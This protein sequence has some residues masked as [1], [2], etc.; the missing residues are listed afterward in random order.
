M[1]KS[2][3]APLP[4]EHANRALQG[5]GTSI[6][7]E[8]TQLAHSCNA[9][10]LGQ[11]FPNFDGPDAI[12]AR[13]AAAISGTIDNQYCRPH[14]L[15]EL[16]RAISRHQQRFW[17]L[18]YDPDREI[19]VT[20]GA[21]EAICSSLLG[22]CN[23]G[24]KVLVFAPFYDAYPACIAMAGAEMVVAKLEGPEFR[25]TPEILEAHAHPDLTTL[26]L[27]Q[28]HN[29]SGRVF[30]ADELTAIAEFCQKH[31]I[32]ALSD[33]VYEHIVF[34]GEH[35]PLAAVGDMHKRCLTI[36]SAG[37]TF[38]LTGWK[39]GHACGPSQLTQAL[40]S[41]HQYVTF[42]TPPALQRAVAAAYELGDDY[43]AELRDDYRQRRDL[44]ITGLRGAGLQAIVPAGSYFALTDIRALGWTD[45][46]SFAIELTRQRKVATIPCSPFYHAG[47]PD[48]QL[49]RWA[50]CKTR[51]QLEQGL[52]QLGDLRVWSAKQRS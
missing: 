44:L 4:R 5:F 9:V 2:A 46:R 45:D 26:I 51:D 3:P 15:P 11:G 43:Y 20:S 17:Q 33:E 16:N 39:V 38:S 24:D 47:D 22:L 42:C 30:D 21:T 28:P 13:A 52:A 48:T 23:P 12:K 41:A 10:N 18:E 27:N 8:M 7:T 34:E 6:F 50:F 25:I 29:P 19:T 31:D 32:V 37:K 14:G 1:P 35:R 36:S 49:V 40:R